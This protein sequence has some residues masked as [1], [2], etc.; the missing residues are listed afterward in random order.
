MGIL[1]DKDVGPCVRLVAERSD[2]F[3]A[4]TPDT[5]RALPADQTAEL[6]KIACAD[7]RV[8]ADPRQAAVLA[9]TL[10]E[11]NDVVLAWRVALYDW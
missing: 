1:S 2:I 4:S 5:P 3:I 11:P 8:C 9:Y 7:V 6:A 10:A